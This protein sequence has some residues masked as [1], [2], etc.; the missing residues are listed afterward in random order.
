MK[1]L[2]LWIFCCLLLIFAAGFLAS[3]ILHWVGAIR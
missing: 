1:L 2:E 3:E